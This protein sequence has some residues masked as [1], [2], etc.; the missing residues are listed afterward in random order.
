ML[1]IHA[2]T[3]QEIHDDCGDEDND[4]YRQHPRHEVKTQIAASR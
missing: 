3:Y 4:D 2:Q 1:L